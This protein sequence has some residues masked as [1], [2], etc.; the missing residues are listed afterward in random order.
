[1]CTNK[2]RAG[3]PV[4]CLEIRRALIDTDNPLERKRHFQA[5]A[6]VILSTDAK[7]SLPECLNY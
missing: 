5:T 7:Y 2:V 6:L 3:L 4:N 1:M